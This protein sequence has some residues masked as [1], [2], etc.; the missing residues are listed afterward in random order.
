MTKNELPKV[1]VSKADKRKQVAIEKYALDSVDQ[2]LLRQLTEYPE[3]TSSELATL[4]GYSV[5]G[6]KK[7]LQKPALR[8]ALAEVQ[9]TTDEALKGLA[10]LALKRL[11]E[12]M[13]SADD[14]V[15]LDACKSVMALHDSRHVTKHPQTGTTA[16]LIYEVQF[17]QDGRLFKQVTEMTD[18]NQYPTTLDIAK[19]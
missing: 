1:A 6:T 11:R 7:R 10:H 8:K 9:Q 15:S 12:L 5:T 17:G 2:V 19:C 4:I 13:L 16:R 14:K 3:S 18:E